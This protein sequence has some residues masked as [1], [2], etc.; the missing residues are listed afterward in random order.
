MYAGVA[1]VTWGK[2]PNGNKPKSFKDMA[3]N[4]GVS[5]PK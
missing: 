3:N 2:L 4:Q 1:S 5:R